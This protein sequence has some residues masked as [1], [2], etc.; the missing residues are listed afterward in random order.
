MLGHM[1]ED[2]PSDVLATAYD[3]WTGDF[4][5]K[6]NQDRDDALQMDKEL[7]ALRAAWS[8]L[9]E[10][11]QKQAAWAKYLPANAKVVDFK[12]SLNVAIGKYNSVADAVKTYSAGMVSVPRVGMAALPVVGAGLIILAAV[13]VLGS[14]AI[15]RD[16]RVWWQGA[17]VAKAE[18]KGYIEQFR[19]VVEAGGG[20]I[21]EVGTTAL[22][23]AAAVA[24][25]GVLYL[26]YRWLQGRR[27]G[28]S[29]A[30]ALSPAAEPK[31]DLVPVEGKVVA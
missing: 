4:A 24:I 31:F 20:V 25:V 13:V 9:P 17:D 6:L 29:S 5:R 1:G 11:S 7:A 23:V 16:L 10:G 22:K 2:A 26:G 8:G 19:D 28:E 12:S 18:A 30:L 14:W 3:I 15:I 21:H 27:G